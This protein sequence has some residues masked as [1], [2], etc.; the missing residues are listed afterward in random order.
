MRRVAAQS[1]STPPESTSELLPL[2]P[3][4]SEAPGVPAP[5]RSRVPTLSE[6]T[7]ALVPPDMQ[8]IKRGI[9]ADGTRNATAVA[10]E[11]AQHFAPDLGAATAA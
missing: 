3:P 1:P 5:S 2:S 8:A 6:T 4:R 9:E 10:A 7:V 11:V